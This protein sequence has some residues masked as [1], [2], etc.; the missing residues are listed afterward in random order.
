MTETFYLRQGECNWCGQC[1]GSGYSFGGDPPAQESPWPKSWPDGLRT[2]S[3]EAFS[4]LAVHSL[5][6][7]VDFV[8]KSGQSNW[9]GFRRNWIFAPNESLCLDLPPYGQATTPGIDFE[10]RCPWLI[11]YG[12]TESPPTACGL[13]PDCPVWVDFCSSSVPLRVNEEQKAVWEQYNPACSY[14]WVAE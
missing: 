1:C 2:W 12:E 14:I 3:V 10:K 5:I 6:K 9:K 7:Q 11:M 13:A 4:Q 8:T